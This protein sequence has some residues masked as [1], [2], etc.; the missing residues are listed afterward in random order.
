MTTSKKEYQ[1]QWHIK[2]KERLSENKKDYYQ[3]NKQAQRNRDLLS[4]YGITLEQYDIM[5]EKQNYS[6]Q[7]CGIHENELETIYKASHH[8]RL[9]VDHC[10]ET[11]KVRGLLCN[12]CNT[13]IGFLETKQNLLTNALDYISE[14]KK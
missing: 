13:F 4:R 14:Y 1:K 12:A 2:N 5:R 7:C 3:K 9:F 11:G 10:H 8:K 6:C